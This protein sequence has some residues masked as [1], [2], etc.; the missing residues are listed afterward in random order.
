M[1][2]GSTKGDTPTHRHQQIVSNNKTSRRATFRQ[3]MIRLS[4][5]N[6]VKIHCPR[7]ASKQYKGASGAN[8]IASGV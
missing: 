4:T 3:A 6:K 8:C 5:N 1:Y 7:R 2:L